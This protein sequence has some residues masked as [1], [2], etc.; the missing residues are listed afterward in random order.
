[1][2]PCPKFEDAPSDVQMEYDINGELFP[3]HC[4]GKWVRGSGGHRMHAGG[5]ETKTGI[6]WHPDDMHSYCEEH[7]PERDKKFFV[8]LWEKTNSELQKKQDAL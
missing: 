1:M 8:K 5:C 2:N 7:C 4:N 6:W 3:P